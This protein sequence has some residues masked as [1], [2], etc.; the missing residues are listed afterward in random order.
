MYLTSQHPVP[1]LLSLALV[2]SL[3]ITGLVGLG[4]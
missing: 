3:T 4:T 2:S 1:K